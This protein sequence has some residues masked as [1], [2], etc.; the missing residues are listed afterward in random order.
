MLYPELEEKIKN[1][2]VTEGDNVWIT[3]YYHKDPLMKP[4]RHVAPILVQITRN[5]SKSFPKSKNFNYHFRPCGQSGKLLA[6]VIL[7]YDNIPY[8]SD[9]GG[10][11]E[12]FFTENEAKM[13]YLEDAEIV[14]AKL[15]KAYEK[16]TTA[17]RA[18][19]AEVDKRIDQTSSSL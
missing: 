3:G 10:S 13:A 4:T 16:W 6:A 12:I 2:E 19:L 15:T 7:P 18:K 11:L 5:G 17:F 8:S 1:G 9:R 14:K